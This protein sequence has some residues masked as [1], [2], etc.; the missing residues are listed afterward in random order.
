M[1]RPPR[2]NCC[3]GCFGC[4]AVGEVASLGN[5]PDSRR[6]QL[7]HTGHWPLDRC[8]AAMRW[9]PAAQL[10]ASVNDRLSLQATA[11]PGP[12][13]S[14]RSAGLE[15]QV[16]EPLATRCVVPIPGRRPER[17]SGLRKLSGGSEAPGRQLPH[18][19]QRR[20]REGL[21]FIGLVVWTRCCHSPRI[22]LTS[23]L[24]IAVAAKPQRLEQ[25]RRLVGEMPSC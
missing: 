25:G 16:S 24:Q 19:A 2:I 21:R 13:Q 15:R 14:L 4:A 17:S 12:L 18:G 22:T 3:C 9:S 23:R 7:G 6:V 10:L 11:G 5:L 20:R 8:R 1:Q